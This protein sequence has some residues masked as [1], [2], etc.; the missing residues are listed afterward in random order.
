MIPQIPTREPTDAVAGD[1]LQWDVEYADYPATAGWE[2]SYA[3][4]GPENLDIAC[5]SMVSAV[6]AGFAVRVPAAA[7]EGLV[8]GGYTLV[9]F[10]A[11]DGE[12]F[13]VYRG[14]LRVAANP[15]A[16]GGAASPDEQLL[17][18]V[19]AAIAGRDLTVEEQRVLTRAVKY[20]GAR[21]ELELQGILRQRVIQERYPD[22]GFDQVLVVF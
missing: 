8:A 16:E 21:N 13:T 15:A 11:K 19:T 20:A 22:R 17:E 4:R 2:L 10:V 12:R 18:L 5:G 9:G 14:P 3:I 7:T 1:S 6:G